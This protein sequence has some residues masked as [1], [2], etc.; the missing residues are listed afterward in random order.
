MKKILL[1]LITLSLVIFS[2]CNNTAI[3]V[4][5]G[6]L[7]NSSGNSIINTYND[8]P[9]STHEQ[10]ALFDGRT[11]ILSSHQTLGVGQSIHFLGCTQNKIVHFERFNIDVTAT[12]VD[13][14]FYENPT[15][16]NNGT[17]IYGQNLERNYIYNASLLLYSTP[18]FTS[19]G[20]LIFHSGI[21]GGNNINGK[22]IIPNELILKLNTC[23]LFEIT[24][25]DGNNNAMIINFIWHE[26][27]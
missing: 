5:D 4:W 6:L 23:Y 20:T 10:N 1:I 22:V 9:T 2:G 8:I 12:P 16:T 15:I 11:Y 24:N 7:R 3:S 18:S 17:I 13:T 26:A 27:D 25:N 14:H 21:F 19:N